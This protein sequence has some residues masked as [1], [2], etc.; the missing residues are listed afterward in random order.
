MNGDDTYIVIP[1]S[2]VSSTAAEIDHVIDRW[3]ESNNLRL[4]RVKSAEILFTDGKR[5]PAHDLPP[6]IPGIRRVTS[7][8]MLGT[9][10]TNHLSVGDQPCP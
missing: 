2:N 6:P 1:A 7:I 10:I 3:A 9:T 4:N 8:K 5:K